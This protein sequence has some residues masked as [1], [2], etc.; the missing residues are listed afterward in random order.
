[1]FKRLM[2]PKVWA[3]LAVAIMVLAFAAWG[4]SQKVQSASSDTYEQLRLFS[5]VLGIV[6]QDYAEQVDS[7][8]LIQ[9]AI[10]GMVKDL[11]P[12]S[13]Y[14]TPEE[15]KDMQVDTK[16]VFG[17]IGI[18]IGVKDGVLTV[19]A[20]IEDTPAAKAGLLAGDK[21]T[22]VNDKPTRDM[23][24][25]EAVA[26]MRGQIGTNVTIHI[27]REGF[28]EPRPFTITRAQ[29]KVK[30]VK[31]KQLPDSFGYIKLAQFQESTS[32]DL[33]KA[34]KEIRP[35][36]GDL[37][38]LVLDMRNNPG[39][40]LSE[41]VNVSKF[42]V[43]SGTIVYTKGRSGGQDIVFKADGVNTEPNY[44]MIVIVN[45]GSA[46][47]SEIVAGALQD[48]KRAIILG[49][50]T[51]G[52]GSVQTIIPL[53]DGSAVRLTTS[54][55]Y[56]P[57]GRSIQAK[58]IEP[59]IV[60]GEAAKAPHIKEKDLAG[61]LAPEAGDKDAK[62]DKAVKDKKAPVDNIKIIENGKGEEGEDI[63]LNRALDYL[64]SWYLFKDRM[65]AQGKAA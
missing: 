30:S 65:P 1:M 21:I 8:K 55:Y 3:G 43:G 31:F 25:S 2:D 53:V 35:K 50:P 14:M 22:K 23:T 47:A 16:G 7:K 19:I 46:S 38:G 28:V 39:G 5:D 61:H 32:S 52:K 63:Q 41:A 29:I 51:F 57:L 37:K 48:H 4:M 27:M 45:G 18:E 40:L 60:V 34:L 36:E 26:Q 33:A 56:T 9:N 15:Y 10:K 59:D 11:D 6:Q 12:H 64:K 58:G 17:G 24:V 54:K 44:P 62:A 13:S 20:P 42:F 49:T